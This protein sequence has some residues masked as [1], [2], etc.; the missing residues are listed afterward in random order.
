MSQNAPISP[1]MQELSAH[2]A[3]TLKRKLPAEVVER[4]KIHL[5]DT[6][7][8]MLSG[9]RQLPGK[10]ALAFVKPLGGTPQAG[11][12]GTRLVTTTLNAALTNGTFGHAD[13]TDDTHPPT[14][15]HPGTSVVRSEERRVGKECR[16]RPL[17]AQFTLSNRKVRSPYDKDFPL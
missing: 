4:G 1:L 2:I 17:L 14:R 7:A 8:S 16:I 12:I 15:S 9:S 5:V 11:I 3:G 6:V 10:R 13:E